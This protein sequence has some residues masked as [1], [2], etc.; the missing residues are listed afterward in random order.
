MNKVCQ[1]N[2]QCQ[3]GGTCMD[4]SCLCVYGYGGSHCESKFTVYFRYVYIKHAIKPHY[5]IGITFVFKSNRSHD[6]CICINRN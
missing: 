4:S 6:L 5:V 2:S 3:N 1:Q